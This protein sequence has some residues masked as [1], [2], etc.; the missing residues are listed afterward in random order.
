MLL[1]IFQIAT[2]SFLIYLILNYLFYK[3]YNFLKNFL[4][5]IISIIFSLFF[6]QDNL[7]FDYKVLAIVISFLI[8][9]LYDIYV[10]ILIERSF[11][12][13]ILFYLNKNKK[14]NSIDLSEHYKKNFKNFIHKRINYFEKNNY[15]YKK[16]SSFYLTPK[17]KLIIKIYKFLFYAHAKK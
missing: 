2:V 12:L 4:F 10:P 3:D 7:I 1:N 8:Q 14:T 16:N 13:S 11:S 6:F 15:I 5:K 17:A 9:F